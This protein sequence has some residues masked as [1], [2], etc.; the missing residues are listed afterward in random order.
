MKKLTEVMIPLST[1][2][3]LFLHYDTSKEKIDA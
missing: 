2:V 1:K 3:L